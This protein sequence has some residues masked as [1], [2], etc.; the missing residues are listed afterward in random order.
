MVKGPWKVDGGAPKEEDFYEEKG[1][2]SHNKQLRQIRKKT[3][4]AKWQVLW[5]QMI[6]I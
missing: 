3:A 6:D 2:R 4:D 1:G 5:Q